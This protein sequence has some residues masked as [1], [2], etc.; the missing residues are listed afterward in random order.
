MLD[1]KGN[2]L[3]GLYKDRPNVVG[4]AFNHLQGINDKLTEHT[5][6]LTRLAGRAWVE[7]EADEFS[8]TRVNGITDAAGQAQLL[9]HNQTGYEKELVSWAAVGPVGA[10]GGI[11]FYMGA[12]EPPNL[13]WSASVTQYSSDKFHSGMIIPVNGVIVAQFLAMGN[14]QQVWANILARRVQ[15]RQGGQYKAQPERGW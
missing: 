3:L 6:L 10:S 2:G 8:W 13:L 12:V 4:D 9:I 11:L 14:A 5:E 7:A 15:H 1:Q